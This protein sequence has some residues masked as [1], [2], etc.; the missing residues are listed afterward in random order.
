MDSRFEDRFAAGRALARA[1]Q[2]YAAQ[3]DLL[4]LALP[5]GGVPVAFE[6]ARA[7]GA[8][9]DV[10][11]VRKLGVPHQP[12]L[13]LGAISSGD[14]LYLNRDLIALT[15]VTKA[16][17]ESV[18]KAERE[19]LARRELLYRGSRPDVRV[20]GRTVI[21]VDDGIATGASMHAALLALRSKHPARIIVAVPVAPAQTQER[22][23]AATDVFISVMTPE[24]FYAVGQFYE[25]FDQT[26]DEEVRALLDR[27]RA[28]TR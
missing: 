9:L 3:R 27:S 16:E 1:L 14:A 20:E 21:V 24:P 8:E 5:R 15:G 25:R 13:A 12:E 10:L 26:S 6:V 18:L 11:I 28:E 19:E 23:G 17:I 22:L 4:V 2:A 7:L